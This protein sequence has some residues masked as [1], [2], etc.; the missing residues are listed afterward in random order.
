MGSRRT[1]RRRNAAIPP[2]M[3]A[4]VQADTD[5]EKKPDPDFHLCRVKTKIMVV[6][7]RAGAHFPNQDWR[8]AASKAAVYNAPRKRRLN[9]ANDHGQIATTTGCAISKPPPATTSTATSSQVTPLS[10]GDMRGAPEE[11][12][13][14]NRSPRETDMDRRGK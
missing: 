11:A 4:R 2:E 14:T 7:V 3:R 13:I 8:K 12:G 10:S 1:A 5:V 6:T 9:G